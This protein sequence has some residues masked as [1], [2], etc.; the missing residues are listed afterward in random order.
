LS[1]A[2][3]QIVVTR[4]PHQAGALGSALE[5]RG[6]V[7]VAYPCIDVALPGD[8]AELGVALDH[9]DRYDWVVVTSPNTTRMLR[10][11]VVD[12]SALKI[13]AVG[14]ATAEAVRKDFGAEVAFTP[15]RQ[16]GD[17]L[18]AEMPVQPGES[19]FVPQ[20]AL[21]DDTV[22]KTLRGRGATVN[23]VTA[24]CNVLGTGGVDLA[25]MLD[26]GEIDAL[27]FTSGST[28]E[29][30]KARLGYIPLDVPAACVGP[31]T[32][33]VALAYGY[34]T[35]IFPESDYSLDGMLDA[36]AGYFGPLL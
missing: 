18:A 32:G 4:A 34:N 19:V 9:L 33:E 23:A 12:W 11:F 15:S 7:P 28:V 30:L 16:I 5:K 24:Y 6:A 13:A 25:A 21:A 29:N 17:V 10:N 26:R 20:S 1:L 31:A 2:G 8:M 14:A 35:V 22:A 36:L 3:K 27:T